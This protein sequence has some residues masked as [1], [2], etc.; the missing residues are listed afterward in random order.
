MTTYSILLVEDNAGDADYIQRALRR[1]EDGV[2]FEVS[3]VGWLNTALTTVGARSFDAVLLDLSL[4]DSQGL[5]TVVQF[6]ASAPQLPVI[7]MTG[8]DDMVTGINAVRYGA[9]DYLIKGDTGD[10]SLE[11]SIIYAIERKRADMVGKKLLR[12]SIGTLSSAGGGATALVHEHL[13]H[14]ADFLHDLRAYIA[15]NAPA[16]ADSIEA[17]ASN[18][19]IDVVLREIR[20]IVQMDVQSTRPGTARPKK[21]SEEA[22]Q[23]V[24]SLSSASGRPVAPSSARGALLSVIESSGEIGER[25]AVPGVKNGSDDE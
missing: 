7:V 11:R 14:V 21:I 15:R 18:H 20:A 13:A 3:V 25:Y 6:L 10:R 5:D 24:S 4:P 2:R 8:H 19:Q 23:A 9:Q 22:L 17:I 1:S 12:A 16:H